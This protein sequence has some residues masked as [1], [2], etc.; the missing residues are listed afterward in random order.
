M[1]NGNRG[2]RAH[3]SAACHESIKDALKTASMFFSLNVARA[4]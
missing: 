4:R 3:G 1:E 2:R